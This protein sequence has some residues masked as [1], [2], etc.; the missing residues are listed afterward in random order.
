M[1]Y[2]G[3]NP[4]LLANIEKQLEGGDVSEAVEDE[5]RELANCHS[6]EQLCGG[7]RVLGSRVHRGVHV[8]VATVR[9]HLH[10]IFSTCERLR[11]SRNGVQPIVPLA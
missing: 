6:A 2:L 7:V 4:D 10:F 8:P 11:L 9:H 5:E 3:A 1:F